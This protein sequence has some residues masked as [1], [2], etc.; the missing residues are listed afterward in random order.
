MSMEIVKLTVH[1]N[2]PMLMHNPASMRGS[3]TPNIERGGKKIPLPYDEAKAS[4]Y[5]LPTGQLYVKSDW[6]REAGLIAAAD[7]KDPSRKGRATMTRRF[8]ASVFLCSEFCPLYRSTDNKQPITSDNDDWQIDTRRVVVQRNGILRSRPKIDNW[9][10]ELP[11]EYDSDLME[12]NLILAVMQNAGKSPG[13]G[14]YRVGKKGPFGRFTVE[15]ANGSSGFGAAATTATPASKK[16]RK[17]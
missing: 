4:L 5:V 8:S 12:P 15:L 6:F 1:G 11:F 10:C 17:S 14:D 3:G 13:V 7:V 2:G 16:K 9:A